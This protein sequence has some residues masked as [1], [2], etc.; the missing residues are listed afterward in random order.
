MN[1]KGEEGVRIDTGF[2]AGDSVTPY[3]DPMIAKVIVHGASRAEALAALAHGARRRRRHRA[4]DQSRFPAQRWCAARSFT[5][6]T[7]DTG[8]IDANLGRLGRRAA[9]A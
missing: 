6:G 2:A 4:E 7:I 1:F 3:Y 8:F 5:A 9:S